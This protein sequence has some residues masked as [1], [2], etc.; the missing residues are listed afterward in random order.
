MKKKFTEA[1]NVFALRQWEWR[2][3]ADSSSSRMRT[4]G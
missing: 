4:G 3:S 2:S 1:Q